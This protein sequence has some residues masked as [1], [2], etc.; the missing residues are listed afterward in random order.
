MVRPEVKTVIIGACVSFNRRWYPFGYHR[1]AIIEPRSASGVQVSI[2]YVICAIIYC[3]LAC[4]LSVRFT[5]S[6]L[7]AAVRLA[8]LDPAGSVYGAR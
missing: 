3:T 7:R 6:P 4:A 5:V 2:G 1:H 8:T